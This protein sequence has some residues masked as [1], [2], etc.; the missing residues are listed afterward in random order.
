MKKVTVETTVA[1]SIEEVWNAWITPKDI[2]EW[3]AAS[4]DWHTTKAPV[5]LREGGVLSSRLEAKDGSMGFDFK[6]AYTKVENHKIIE[7][8]L[9]DSRTV[10]VEFEQQADGVR[11]RETF[12][13]DSTHPVEQQR[14][15]WQA[16]L[17]RFREYVENRSKN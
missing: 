14:E 10:L 1:T 9:D 12:D 4:D 11:I 3:N 2:M 7:F 15:G 16:I 8:R 6:G 5:D 13:A 17:V